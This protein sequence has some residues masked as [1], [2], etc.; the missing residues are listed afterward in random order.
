[1]KM[2]NNTPR[3][4][5]LL[6]CAAGLLSAA[7]LVY[8]KWGGG[9]AVRRQASVLPDASA[10]ATDTAGRGS[11]AGNS[12][13]R[14][15]RELLSRLPLGFEENRGQLDRRV[16]FFARGPGY[17]LLLSAGGAE[18]RLRGGSPAAPSARRR[19]R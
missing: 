6:L 18:L 1:M 7:L 8:L 10:P 19:R 14:R 17:G 3:P 2:A 5:T 12:S 9:A 11:S 15:A 13:D 4:L 16:N